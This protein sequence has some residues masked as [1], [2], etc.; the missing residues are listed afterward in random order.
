ML[1]KLVHGSGQMP[2][3]QHSVEIT[4][5]SGLSYE[6]VTFNGLTNWDNQDRKV[7]REFG[8]QWFITQRS[9]VLL[10]PSVVARMERNILINPFHPDFSSVTHGIAEP[11][12]WD[13]R[14]FTV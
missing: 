8:E 3:N 14:L 12:R 2:P 1:E 4:I 13:E 11:V 10:V 7:S 6:E 5:P 9:L